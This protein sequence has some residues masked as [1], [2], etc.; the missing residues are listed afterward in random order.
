MKLIPY[1]N[2]NGNCR[3]AMDFYADILGA[4]LSSLSYGDSPAIGDM[5]PLSDEDKAKIAH[6]QLELDGVPIL[7]ASDS[8][9]VFGHFQTA[10]GMQ[11]AITVDTFADGQ[12][13]FDALADGGHVQMPYGKTFWAA[14]CGILTDRFGTPWIINGDY[15]WEP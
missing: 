5:P 7:C 1:L 9:P 2:F 14:G 13:I 10:Q 4:V 15:H 11:V 6:S 12:R 8:L 3:E